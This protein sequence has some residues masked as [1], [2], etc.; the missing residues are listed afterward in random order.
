MKNVL[1]NLK[2]FVVSFSRGMCIAATIV[3]IILLHDDGMTNLTSP[4]WIKYL[5]LFSFIVALSEY[6]YSNAIC[7]LV[8]VIKQKHFT[9]KLE[10]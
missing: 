6:V 7:V 8:K 5:L 1:I 3:L 10:G 4:L 9:N 2:E